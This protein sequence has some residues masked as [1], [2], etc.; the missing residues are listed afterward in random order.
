MSENT[1]HQPDPSTQKY[2]AVL[3]SFT[4]E[5]AHGLSSAEVQARFE[6]YGPNR[7]LEFK[8]RSA[9]AIL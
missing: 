5:R 4:V 6:R 3:E 8:P 7:L 2:E 1:P 9:W